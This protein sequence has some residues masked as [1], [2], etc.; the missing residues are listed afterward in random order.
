MNADQLEQI[1][2]ILDPAIRETTRTVLEEEI[3]PFV[4]RIESLE[5]DNALL[6]A[7]RGKMFGIW[8][9][10]VFVASIISKA[11]YD[12]FVKKFYP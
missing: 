4:E 11:V 7:S 1:K 12:Y 6:K 8:T 2:R 5:A 9:L 10:I 3:R